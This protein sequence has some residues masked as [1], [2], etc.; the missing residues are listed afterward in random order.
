MVKPEP[1][2]LGAAKEHLDPNETL[3]TWSKGLCAST[4]LGQET[5]RNGF[6]LATDQRVLVFINKLLGRFELEEFPYSTMS[7]IE[8]GKGLLGHSVKFI[9]SG[10]ALRVTMMVEGDPK[11]LYEYVRSRIGKKGQ[12]SEPNSQNKDEADF[13]SKLAQ[14]ADLRERGFL[15]TDEFQRAKRKAS[16]QRVK[17]R[18]RGCN[19]L[20]DAQGEPHGTDTPCN[21]SWLALEPKR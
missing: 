10:N 12:G 17:M 7:S 15:T 6:I 2:G 3:V 16:R 14:L 4:I 5:K 8:H 21:G 11:G 13:P 18:M 9:A 20:Q 1:K 19:W